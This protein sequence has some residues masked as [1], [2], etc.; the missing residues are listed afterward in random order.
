MR[1]RTVRAAVSTTL[2]VSLLVLATYSVEPVRAS[3]VGCSPTRTLVTTRFAARSTR[4]TVPV[5]AAPCTGSET[6]AVPSLSLVR[7]SPVA[8][9]PPSFD[10]Q[11]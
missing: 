3:A 5:L 11:A 9:R 7:S 4:L 1:L 8:R 6:I 10:T 2:T